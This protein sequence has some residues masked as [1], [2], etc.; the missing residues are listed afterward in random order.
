MLGFS[1]KTVLPKANTDAWDIEMGKA[2]EAEVQ[3]PRP[4]GICSEVLQAGIWRLWLVL[5]VFYTCKL[6]SSDTL[7]FH[8][9]S[10]MADHNAY[11]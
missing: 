1:Q 8:L 5:A 3:C 10:H 9:D 6:Y 11:G 4:S 7:S 2:P